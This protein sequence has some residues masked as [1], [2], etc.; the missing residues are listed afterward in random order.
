MCQTHGAQVNHF[1]KPLPGASHV[2]ICCHLRGREE[3]RDPAAHMGGP[4]GGARGLCVRRN[5][6]AFYSVSGF[7]LVIYYQLYLLLFNFF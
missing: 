3:V 4:V 5:Q 1:G 2:Y 7:H 6:A